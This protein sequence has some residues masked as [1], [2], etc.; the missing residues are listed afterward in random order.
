MPRE[1]TCPNTRLG[2]PECSCRYCLIAL[3]A[4]YAPQVLKKKS[5]A[6]EEDA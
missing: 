2:I 3:V 6:N 4:L 5:S 1:A